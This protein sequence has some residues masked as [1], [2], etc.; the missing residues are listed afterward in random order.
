MLKENVENLA[1]VGHRQENQGQTVGNL[2]N[3][4]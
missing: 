1:H 2:F 4:N 3:A